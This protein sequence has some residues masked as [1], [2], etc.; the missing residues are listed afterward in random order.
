MC[1]HFALHV[2]SK[3]LAMVLHHKSHSNSV[4]P[5]VQQ[6]ISIL[7]IKSNVSHLDEC[8]LDI[9]FCSLPMAKFLTKIH[10]IV[11]LKLKQ[12]F[13]RKVEAELSN[14]MNNDQTFQ[15]E[16]YGFRVLIPEGAVLR[17]LIKVGTSDQFASTLHPLPKFTGDKSTVAF[18]MEELMPRDRVST[19]SFYHDGGTHAT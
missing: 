19:V 11:S 6:Y 13:S 2:L 9:W 4:A 12:Q 8:F 15:C 3:V 10:G 17:I 7:K 16:E 5:T 18:M 14:F 1:F